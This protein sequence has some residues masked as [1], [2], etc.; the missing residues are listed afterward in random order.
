MKKQILDEALNEVTSNVLEQTAFVFT[1]PADMS[2]GLDFGDFEMVMMTLQY[3]GDEH[4][5]VSLVL[6][7]E[8]CRELSE[9][10]LGVD[11]VDTD[12]DDMHLDSAK[13]LVNMIAGQLMT[14]LFGETAVLNLS[15][16]QIRTLPNEELQEEISKQSYVCNMVDDYPVITT[17][18]LAKESHEH[19][20]ISS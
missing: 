9:N 14:Q 20:G 2:D 7:V 11:A 16:P 13:E 1:E 15:P 5:T 8:F 19:Q 18:S 17:L 6:P 12:S 3:S 10:M 4:G